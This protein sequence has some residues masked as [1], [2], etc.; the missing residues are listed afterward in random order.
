[1]IHKNERDIYQTLKSVFGYDEFRLLQEECINSVLAKK[2]TLLVMPTGGGKSICYQI[3]ALMFEGLTVVVSP[4]IS[5]MQDQMRQLH[6]V[7]VEA[8][9]L[10]STLSWEEYD[11]VQSRVYAGET[12]MLFL[13]PETLM[14]DNILQMLSNISVDCVTIDEAHCISEW[15]HDFRPE[16]RQLKLI[17]NNFPK[18]VYLAMTAT[19]TPRV[20]E[21]IVKNLQLDSVEELVASFNR[22]NLFYEVLPKDKPL[23]QTMD[24]LNRFKNQSGIIYCS[25]RKQVDQLT[26]N[27]NANGFH[28]LPYHAGLS[29]KVRRRNQESFICDDT[30][31]MVAT[32]AFGMGINK[33]NVRFV[34]HYDLPKSIESYYQ[35]TGRAGRD[36]LPA[37][38]LLLFGYGDIRKV[39]YFIDQKTDD[40]QKKSAQTHLNAI[41]QYAE[42]NR[43]RRIPLINY[44]GED[45]KEKTCELCDNCVNPKKSDYDLSQYAYKFL[46]CVKYTGQRFGAT[47]V[48]DVLRGGKGQKVL[49]YGHERL[50]IHGAGSDYS[51]KQWQYVLRQFIEQG[52]LNKEEEYG[53]LKITA[54]G[55][56]LLNNKE[57]FIGYAPPVDKVKS[58]APRRT[59]AKDFD[60]DLFE[61]LRQIRK[62]MAD[63]K[64]V[65]PYIIFSDKSLIDMSTTFPQTRKDLSKVFGVGTKKLETYGDIFLQA[66]KDYSVS[67]LEFDSEM[68]E[69][70]YAQ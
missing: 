60:R 5:L 53:V 54:K 37:H 6:A 44:F 65:P 34:I 38:C 21:D 10:N 43:C 24:F 51:L 56:T 30:Q 28:S 64:R 7:G 39:K 58:K 16:Y 23:D 36:G 69:S 1:M 12:K 19:A 52:L 3:P 17:R 49:N 20:R 2:D 66:I 70:Q 31:I 14:K 57:V 68:L 33:P 62:T 46:E 55:Q 67:R 48:I 4:L 15:G 61:I 63:K 26:G 27:L 47:H 25:S 45:Y 42:D 29:D 22:Y 35:E 18:A 11:Q 59:L 40:Q 9:V 8:D 32:I 41:I 50:D 13:A